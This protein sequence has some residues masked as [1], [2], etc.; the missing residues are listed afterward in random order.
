MTPKACIAAMLMASMASCW[1][2]AWSGV[3]GVILKVE[4][5]GAWRECAIKPETLHAALARTLSGSGLK[6]TTEDY[7]PRLTAGLQASQVRPDQCALTVS[8]GLSKFSAADD[9]YVLADQI[10]AELAG[11]PGP[12]GQSAVAELVRM[13]GQFLAAW[14]KANDN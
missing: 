5:G 13:T 1:A 12:I 10:K 2:D 9:A 3:Q 4:P 8:L 7:E 14:R 6:V 11:A